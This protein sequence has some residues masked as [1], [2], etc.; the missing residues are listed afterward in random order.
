MSASPGPTMDCL[1]IGGGPAGL[2]AAIYLARFHLRVAVIDEGKSR[3]L[4]IAESHNL[5]GFP[6]GISGADFLSLQ[7]EHAL[8]YGAAIGH[9]RVE[10]LAL[11][12]AGF[13]ARTSEASWTARSVLLATGVTNR[14][15]PLDDDIHAEALYRGHL[16]YCPVCDGYEVTGKNVAV[17]GD[18]EKA[19]A[20]CE[21]LR[22]FT[23]RL[24]MIST[25]ARLPDPL[26]RRLE[27]SG[28]SLRAGPITHTRLRSSGLEI[29]TADGSFIYDAV[30]PS[31]G[32]SIHSSLA[33]KLGAAATEDGCIEVDRHQRTTVKNL[34]AAGDV[35]FGLDQISVCNGQAAIAAVAIR[36][37]LNEQQP[38]LWP[39]EKH[40]L[41]TG[42]GD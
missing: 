33:R 34:Y 16:R 39:L 25:G 36:N 23:D 32:S 18:D 9:G 21:F 6:G 12:P 14:R 31:L 4:L 28:V 30:Y 24:T 40:S 11:T 20:E 37:D 29:K 1:I 19:V 22:S 41:Q 38:Q 27:A 17:I 2:T 15:P 3:A 8:L 5:P 13:I 42:L 26:R 7:R 10:D 35:V